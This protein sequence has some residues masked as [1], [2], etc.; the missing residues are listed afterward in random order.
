MGRTSAASGTRARRGFA[1]RVAT[2]GTLALTAV[3]LLTACG[4]SGLKPYT[5]TSPASEGAEGINS[6]YKLVFWLALVVFV[7]VQFAIVYT[8]LRFRKKKTPGQRPPQIH[9]NSRLEITWTILPAVV[10]LVILVPTITTLFDEHDALAESDLVI[11]VYGKQWWWEMQYGEDAVQGGQSLGVITANELVIPA[12]RTVKIRLHSNNVIHSF[13][14]PRLAGKLDVIPGH[15]NEMTIKTDKT[16][17]YYGECA[18]FCG[19]EHAWMRF[20]VIVTDQDQFYGWVN[21]WREGNL[22]ATTPGDGKNLPE[23]VTQAPAKFSLCLACHT[24]NGIEG[25]TGPD[26]WNVPGEGGTSL[27]GINAPANYGPNLTNIA[28]RSTIAAGMLENNVDNMTLWLTDPAKVKPDT[29]MGDVIKPSDSWTADDAREM[30]EFLETLKPAGGCFNE[31]AAA[32][33]E[34]GTPAASP[35][36]VAAGTPVASPE[37]A[38]AGTPVAASPASSPVASPEASPV[39]SPEAATAVATP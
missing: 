14:V 15:V 31:N 27:T 17:E 9:G 24:V 3:V 35:E 5:T 33:P 1:G 16:G 38:P 28:C 2:L 6:L 30:A 18:E 25:S 11:D 19:T 37:A 12:N 32:A 39:A 29:Y 7:G 22:I 34:A 36:A 13:W 21:G 26:T 8:A 10:L 23:G 4:P 20:K